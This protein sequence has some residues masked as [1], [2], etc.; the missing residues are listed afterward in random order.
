MRK[1][2]YGFCIILLILSGNLCWGQE[3]IIERQTESLDK[4]QAEPFKLVKPDGR[5]YVIKVKT[6]E[7]FDGINEAITNAIAAGKKNILV[8]IANGVYYFHENHIIRINEH[9]TDVSITILGMRTV[10]TSDT[11]YLKSQAV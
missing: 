1:L 8:K 6:Q 3:S 2:I 5:P 11:H 9:A 10:I 4:I 7:Q